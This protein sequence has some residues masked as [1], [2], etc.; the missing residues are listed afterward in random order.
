MERSR[1]EEALKRV[2][3]LQYASLQSEKLLGIRRPPMSLPRDEMDTLNWRWSWLDEWLGS[4]H[5]STRTLPSRTSPVHQRCA[6]AAPRRR[7][8]RRRRPARLFLGRTSHL[9]LHGAIIAPD[10][11][12][13]LWFDRADFIV[14]ASLPLAAATPAQPSGLSKSIYN[15]CNTN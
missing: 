15:F 5:P 11:R 8:R 1:E 13:R 12:W 6:C 10:R 4:Q 7:R 3:A 14:P 2:R 9:H